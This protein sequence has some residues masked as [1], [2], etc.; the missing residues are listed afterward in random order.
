M[1]PAWAM[2]AVAG[3]R[4]VIHKIK[5][6]ELSHVTYIRGISSWKK[7]LPYRFADWK[8]KKLGLKEVCLMYCDSAMKFNFW[9]RAVASKA[10]PSQNETLFKSAGLTFIHMDFNSDEVFG[11][12]L[13]FCQNWKVI[14]WPQLTGLLKRLTAPAEFI[15]V[16]HSICNLHF[17][18][19]W[20]LTRTCCV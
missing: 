7:P 4:Q 3:P 9:E 13:H 18:E 10:L 5:A 2:R 15:T 8:L 20:F 6:A 11:S 19:R 17:Q 14:F 16:Q 1:V 12:Q